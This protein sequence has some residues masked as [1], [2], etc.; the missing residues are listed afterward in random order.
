VRID[1]KVTCLALSPN[2]RTLAT[3]GWA[4]TI[5]LWDVARGKERRR[6][7]GHRGTVTSLAWSTDGNT[8]ISGN[9]TAC[10]TDPYF[11]RGNTHRAALAGALLHPPADT[12]AAQGS[13]AMRART[14]CAIRWRSATMRL[15]AT[16]ID[17]RVGGE[18]RHAHDSIGV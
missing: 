15:W 4:P 16:G 8:L 5:R 9:G 17:L 14:T 13:A 11:N 3:V 12:A 18:H 2:G 6:L 10:I 7:D 1:L